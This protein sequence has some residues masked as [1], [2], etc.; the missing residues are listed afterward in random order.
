MTRGRP[1]RLIG[2]GFRR[3]KQ[4]NL[5]PIL[6][7]QAGALAFVRDVAAL[8]RLAPTAADTLFWWSAAPPE[9]VAE[10]ARA[11]G[12]PTLR[13][14][15][16]F[17]RS[18]GLGSDLI[19]PASLVLDRTGL[20]FDP[21]TPSDLETLLLTADFDAEECAR[22]QA[23][24]AFVVEH[25]LTKYNLEPRRPA[26]WATQGRR[27]I[28]VPGQVE[29]DASIRFGCTGVRTNAGLLQTARAEA[30]DAFIVYKPHPDVLSGNRRGR[31]A[32][33]EAGRW[34]DHIE[35]DLSV[36]SAIEAADAVHVMT[37][38][39]G[40]DALL[41][42][43]A[44]V[45]HG[46]PFYAGWG[47]TDDRAQGGE[48][49]MRRTRRLSLDQLVAGA[50]LRYPLYWDAAQGRPTSCEAVLHAL[51][52]QRD[53]LERRGQLDAL[54]SGFWRRQGRKLRTLVS[55]ALRAR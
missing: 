47:L 46:Q 23:V 1:G 13:L 3:W 25:G 34:A 9:G 54:R 22:A 26:R 45:T 40:F 12:L 2:V 38:Q 36:I 43:K 44:V 20:Y 19:P 8:R 29:D 5:A 42:G 18:V 31:M 55:S 53:T 6:R 30:P 7:S 27:V 17:F 48:A 33:T 37:S 49:L 10:F 16:G 51:Q 35:T 15:D 41:R 24:R 14:E 11:A 52:R 50:L 39:A 28:L 32:L 4:A 21:R